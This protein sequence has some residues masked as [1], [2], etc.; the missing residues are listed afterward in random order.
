MASTPDSIFELLMAASGAPADVLWSAVEM[1]PEE[2]RR[3][4]A[5]VIREVRMH[6]ELNEPLPVPEPAPATAD[7][8]HGSPELRPGRMPSPVR[9]PPARSMTPAPRSN[10]MPGSKAPTGGLPA[11]S[12]F[13]APEPPAVK[14]IVAGLGA[15]RTAEPKPP[16]FSEALWPS[17]RRLRCSS[18]RRPS[19]TP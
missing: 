5:R 12:T 10:K 1:M 11:G 17:K 15:K 19:T 9:P 4:L 8:P 7:P 16:P 6:R 3:I 18:P 14:S 2:N 13:L